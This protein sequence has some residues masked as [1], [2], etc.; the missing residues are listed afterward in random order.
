[1]TFFKNIF[2]LFLLHRLYRRKSEDAEQE[3][4]YL[5]TSITSIELAQSVQKYISQ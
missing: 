3:F 4:L 5:T 1:M 2:K